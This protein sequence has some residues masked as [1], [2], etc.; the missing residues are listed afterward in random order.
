MKPLILVLLERAS[1]L[2]G[3]EI[4][5]QLSLENF[6]EVANFS[7]V[8]QDELIKKGCQ[9]FSDY[10]PNFF[11][12]R[13]FSGYSVSDLIRVYEVGKAFNTGLMKIAK[14]NILKQ[15]D[16]ES[17]LITL[18]EYF[19]KKAIHYKVE[20]EKETESPVFSGIEVLSPFSEEDERFKLEIVLIIKKKR[21]LHSRIMTSENDPIYRFYYEAYKNLAM[22]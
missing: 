17:D 10:R 16:F 6:I 18:S 12:P 20:K 15:F 2:C 5:V 1:E 4:S 3:E 19:S 11:Y 13:N 9:S 22:N 8:Y 21:G 7:L 14:D